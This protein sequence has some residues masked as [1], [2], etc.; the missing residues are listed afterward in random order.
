MKIETH[1]E[2]N[3]QLCGKPLEVEDGFSRVGLKTTQQMRAD[4]TGLIHGG[5]ILGN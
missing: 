2:I 5:F 3:A 1:Q 4:K